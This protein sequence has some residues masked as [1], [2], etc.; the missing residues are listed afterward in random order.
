MPA[1]RK[2]VS[3]CRSVCY[4]PW[5]ADSSHWGKCAK[6]AEQDVA[7]TLTPKPGSKFA[8]SQRRWLSFPLGSKEPVHSSCPCRTFTLRGMWSQLVWPS[9]LSAFLFILMMPGTKC[10]ASYLQGQDSTTELHPYP[11]F[12]K[13]GCS[14]SLSCLFYSFLNWYKDFSEEINLSEQGNCGFINTLLSS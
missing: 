7:G 12:S 9:L 1:K 8:Y 6:R 14:R 10:K 13:K 2:R 4:L 3:G 11:F 5:T